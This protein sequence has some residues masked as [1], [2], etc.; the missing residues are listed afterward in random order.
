MATIDFSPL[1]VGMSGRAGDAIF[2]RWK[3]RAYVRQ[4]VMPHNPKSD[5]QMIVRNS[6]GRLARL[7]RSLSGQIHDEQDQ[8]AAGYALSG[9]NWFVKQNR[10]LEQAYGSYHLTPPDVQIDAIIGLGLADQGAGVC[11]VTWSGGERGADYMI[12]VY[13]RDGAAPN[14]DGV[15]VFLN[16]DDTL[17]SA[18]TQDFFIGPDLSRRVIVAVENV[19]THQFSECVSDVV[20]MGA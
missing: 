14:V 15:F 5:A 13:K 6:L 16:S 12:H 2:S 4:F 19:A 8:Y 3:G 20:V 1:V 10:V 7:W 18:E 17:V 9:W 11:R